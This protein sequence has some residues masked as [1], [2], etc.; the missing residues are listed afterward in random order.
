MKVRAIRLWN[1]RK[2]S[3]RGVAIEEIGDGV[4][5]LAAENEQGKSTCFDALHA[6]LFQPHSGTPKVVQMLRPYSGGS[7]R[8]EADIETG[9]GLYRIVKQFYAGREAT[10]T[11]LATQRLIAQA[12]QAEAWIADLTRGGAS[13]PTGLLWVRQGLTDFDSGGTAQQKQEFKARE[14]ALASVAGEVEALTGG[15]RMAWILQRCQDELDELVTATG[16]ARKGGAY[17]DAKEEHERLLEEENDLANRVDALRGELDQRKTMQGQRARLTDPTAIESRRLD[18]DRTAAALE[19]ARGHAHKLS[20][21]LGQHEVETQLHDVDLA[22]LNRYR[23]ALERSETLVA[24]LDAG[25]HAHADALAAQA[26]AQKAEEDTGRGLRDAEAD[27]AAAREQHRRAEAAGRLTDIQKQLEELSARL[28]KAE[29]CQSAIEALTGR[30]QTLAIPDGAVTRLQKLD[31]EIA[32]LHAKAEASSALVVIDYGDNPHGSILVDGLP[33][34]NGEAHPVSRS[35]RFDI[36]QIGGLTVSAGSNTD[37]TT[38]RALRIKQTDYAQELENLGVEDLAALRERERAFAEVKTRLQGARAELAA[39]APNGVDALKIEISRLEQ[40]TADQESD[41]PDLKKAVKDVE[42]ADSRLQDARIAAETTRAQLSSKREATSLERLRIDHL[43]ENHRE[44]NNALGPEDARPAEFD[45]L[46]KAE[47]DR[48]AKLAAT[49]KQLETLKTSAPDLETAE[50]AA[51][52]A[53]SVVERADA[54]IARLDQEIARLSGSITSRSDEAV[55]ETLAETRDRLNAASDRVAFLEVEIA[56]LRR[57]KQALGD[58]RADARE[59]YLG[60][61]MEELRPLLALLFDEGTITFDDDTLLPRSLER[62][63]LDED[64]SVLSGGMREQ[65]TVLTRLAFAR[66]LAKNGR[67]VPVI[68]DDAL[69]YSDDDR[70]EKMFIALHRQ[71]RDLQIIVFS[72][73]QRAFERLGGHSLHMTGWTPEQSD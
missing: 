36:P 13:G 73:R 46:V 28:Q 31:E 25:D 50:A 57:L 54:D 72:C 55:E 33:V 11:D 34:A 7:P 70:I 38:T 6:L 42:K 15:R 59:R 71:A 32:K 10:V 63:G 12:D 22:A 47:A 68:L 56:V 62:N 65:L 35:T 9:I 14:D 53:A 27:Y 23:A 8:I 41:T 37:D 2:F 39:W 67:S 21:A 30:A 3:R 48:G 20:E 61:V 69:V 60:P 24:R 52:L 51:R 1:V 43:R 19:Q 5:V 44:I 26:L 66:L 17:A 58:A 45:R 49:A 18:Q 64:V 40:Q 4:N 16:L 29:H